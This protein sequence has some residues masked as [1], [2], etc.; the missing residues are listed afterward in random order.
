MPYY[1]LYYHLVWATKDR[2]P[3][4]VPD[5]EADL[6]Q[7]LRGKAISLGVIVHAVGGIEEH[8]H[9][10]ASIPPRLAVATVIGQLKGAS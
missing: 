2:E 9:I 10:A 7:Y 5:L 4:I 1:E 6:H 8:V 3:L